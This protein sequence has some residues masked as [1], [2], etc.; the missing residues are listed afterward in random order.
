M[1][2]DVPGVSTTAARTC[3]VAAASA[4]VSGAEI[5]T[6]IV[7]LPNPELAADTVVSP[8]SES[9]ATAAVTS[10]C[11]AVASA[12]SSKVTAKIASLLPPPPRKAV[13]AASELP[14]VDWTVVTPGT[15]EIVD[16]TFLAAAS[17]VSSE[18]PAG[19]SGQR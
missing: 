7:L 4:P 9:P 2:W 16:S 3:F 6:S 10:F 12:F 19:S 15:A 18:V 11:T 5:S 8:T 13:L 17:V 1:V 14:T